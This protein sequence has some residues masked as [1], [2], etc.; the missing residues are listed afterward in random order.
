MT[1]SKCASDHLPLYYSLVAAT[2]GYY[3][4]LQFIPTISTFTH[5]FVTK[6]TSVMFSLSRLIFIFFISYNLHHAIISY[7]FYPVTMIFAWFLTEAVPLQRNIY[8]L[9][10]FFLILFW[11]QH[12]L[13]GETEKSWNSDIFSQIIYL[14]FS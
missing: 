12:L 10:N 13:F 14:N 11:K 8:F 6:N 3:Y 4:S 5:F 7:N 1:G 9:E 2:T